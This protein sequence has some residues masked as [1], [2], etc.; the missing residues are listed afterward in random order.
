VKADR[1]LGDAQ[2]RL[3]DLLRAPVHAIG[4]RFRRTHLITQY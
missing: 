2:P 4:P 1:G 3:V